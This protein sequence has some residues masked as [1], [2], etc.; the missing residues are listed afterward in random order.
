MVV[1]DAN[2]GL[3]LVPLNGSGPQRMAQDPYAEIRDAAFSPDGRWLAYSTQ[4]ATRMRAIHLRELASGRDTVISSPFESD[5]L[6]T[7]TSDGRLLAFVSQRNEQPFVS[8]RDDESLVSTLN[9]DGVYAA[10]L[11]RSA[12]PPIVQAPGAPTAVRVDLDGL[13][14]RAVALPVTPGVIVSLEARGGRL[15]YE[16]KPP[17]LIDGDLAGAKS[18]LHAYD[19]AARTDGVV[20][21][22]LDSHSLS[23]DGTKVAFRREGSWRLA[24]TRP[25]ASAEVAL[26]GTGLRTEVDPRR[27]WAEMFNEAWR[28]DRDIFFSRSMNGN[29]WARVRDAYQPLIPLLGSQDDFLYLLGQLQGEL[30]SSHTFLGRGQDFD[31]RPHTTTPLLGADYALDTASGRYRFARIYPGDNSRPQLRG[32]LGTPGLDIRPGDYLLAVNGRDLRAPSPPLSVFAGAKE[33]LVL[34]VA[35]SPEGPGRD[36]KVNPVDDDQ[37]LRTLAWVEQNRDTV[38]KASHDRLGY[39]YLSDFF[40]DGSREFVRQFYPQLDKDGLIIDVRWNRGGFTSQ[41]VL[42]VLRRQ[43]AGVFVNRE[44]ALSPL[45]M[46]TAPRAM[47]TLMN[48]GSGSD[49]DQFAYFFR[50][51][52]LGPLVGSRTWGGVQGVNGPWRLTNGSFITIPKDAL[53]GRDGRWVI[54]N[55]G[56]APD[57]LVESAPDEAETG[58]D[59]QL[60]AA[61]MAGLTQLKRHPP[62]TPR[63]PAALPAYPVGGDVPGAKFGNPR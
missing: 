25:G 31:T 20:V 37:P 10:A 50:L 51:Y 56:V 17:Q 16:T 57:I 23:A 26:D 9:S 63:A 5:R 43:A 48:D 42:E 12:P 39:I 30:A 62:V 54:E 59:A 28:L 52:G 24:A 29:D 18:A 40:G 8:D 3:W 47:V 35:H 44:A 4:R 2:H 33:P 41:A 22:D 34:T 21:E 14:S 11:D 15:F 32:P 1:A 6:P 60:Q 49:A 53:A 45:P 36:V 46:A 61:V 38:S 27:E 19:L 13:M 58:H 55:E 7:F